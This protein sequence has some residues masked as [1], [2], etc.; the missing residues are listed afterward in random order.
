MPGSHIPILH[1]EEIIKKRPDYL[2]ILPWNISEE[3][4][5][6]SSILVIRTIKLLHYFVVIFFSFKRA[7]EPSL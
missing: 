6:I 1:P 7:C 5:V 4:I 3:I 2:L